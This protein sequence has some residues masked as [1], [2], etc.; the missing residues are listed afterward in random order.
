MASSG[1]CPSCGKPDRVPGKHLPTR[2]SAARASRRAAIAEPLA[3]SVAGIDEITRN[4][5]V[6]VLVT[7]GRVVRSL[8]HGRAHVRRVAPRTDR[9]AVVFKGGHREFP[10]SR[11]L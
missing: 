11:P 10:N 3:V 5:K 1:N 7:S 4:S 2:A 9:H 8:P 6:P